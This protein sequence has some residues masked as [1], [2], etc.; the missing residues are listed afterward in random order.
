MSNQ[1]SYYNYCSYLFTIILLKI[2]GFYSYCE[3]F[4]PKRHALFAC[5]SGVEA[6]AQYS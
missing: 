1:F 5:L 2:I 4:T 6:V 3:C